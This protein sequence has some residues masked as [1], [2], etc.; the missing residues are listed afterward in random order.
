MAP[1]QHCCHEPEMHYFKKFMLFLLKYGSSASCT[2]LS[3]WSCSVCVGMQW[4]VSTLQGFVLLN[5]NGQNWAGSGRWHFRNKWIA[6]NGNN[7][8]PGAI[9][10]Q[11]ENF[12]PRI[13]IISC[14]KQHGDS[15]ECVCLCSTHCW[16]HCGSSVSSWLFCMY[17]VWNTHI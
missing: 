14:M 4:M 15:G 10:F 3:Y 5:L 8:N 11:L 16:C 7:L 1:G 6:L 12:Q 2:A 13:L 17:P 9:N